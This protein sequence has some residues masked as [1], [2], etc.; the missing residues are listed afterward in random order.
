MI[1]VERVTEKI[2]IIE[3]HNGNMVEL[4][5]EIFEKE[6]REGDILKECDGVYL[7]DKEA[8]EQR[9]KELSD[10]ADSLFSN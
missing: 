2:V 5:R 1:S 3:D 7:I 10:L 9:K 8:T 4:P 6:I